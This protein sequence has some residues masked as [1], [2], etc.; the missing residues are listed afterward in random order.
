MTLVPVPTKTA[1]CHCYLFATCL[2]LADWLYLKLFEQVSGRDPYYR[3]LF[4]NLRMYI[5]EDS[6]G[7]LFQFGSNL[8][9]FSSHRITQMIQFLSS[10]CVCISC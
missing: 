10:V 8:E 4:I 1:R 6:L 5:A 3:Y 2:G 7:A 9:G